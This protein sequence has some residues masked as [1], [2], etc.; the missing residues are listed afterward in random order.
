MVEMAGSRLVVVGLDDSSSSTA[1]HRW[2]ARYAQ[3]TGAV[4]RA[5]HVLT[6]RSD[7]P[8]PR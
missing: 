3:A 1:A 2:A 6:W 7:L 4:L 8:R 5:V